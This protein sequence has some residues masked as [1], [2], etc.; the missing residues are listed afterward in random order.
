MFLANCRVT[1][2]AFSN[3]VR[4]FLAGEGESGDRYSCES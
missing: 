4:S 3:E 1:A 2:I